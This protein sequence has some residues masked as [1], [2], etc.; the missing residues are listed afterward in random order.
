[1]PRNA[2][3][4]GAGIVLMVLFLFTLT[5][6]AETPV[7]GFVREQGTYRL[8][9]KG[10]HLRIFPAKDG[11][12][13]YEFKWVKIGGHETDSAPDKGFF[14]GEGWFAYIESV[15]RIWIYDGKKH[16]NIVHK[17][18]NWTGFYSVAAQQYYR[19]CPDIV[20]SALP[21]AVR[22]NMQAEGEKAA[23]L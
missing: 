16:L 14:E 19:T 7:V 20:W 12:P 23:K 2:S 4:P 15:N 9:A 1:M 13:T 22:Q 17:K 10:S 18:E 3:L 21:E 6:S 8:D 11:Q 5:G